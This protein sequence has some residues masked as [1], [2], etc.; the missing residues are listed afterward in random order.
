MLEPLWQD[1]SRR[2][3]LL[4]DIKRQIQQMILRDYKDRLAVKDFSKYLNRL[5]DIILKKWM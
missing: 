1:S 2:E 5:V 3:D 4:K